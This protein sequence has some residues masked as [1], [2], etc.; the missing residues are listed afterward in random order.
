GLREALGK[1]KT[2]DWGPVLD[3]CQWVLSQPREIAGRE[4]RGIE[5]DPDW[6]WTR[7][8]IADLLSAGLENR[9]GS[10]P[11]GFREKVWAILEP[12]TEDPDPTP[13]D[14]QRYGEPNM[15]PATLA[16]NTTRGVAME[17]AIRYALWVQRHLEKGP[18]SKEG[19]QKGFENMPEVREV[20]N[21]HLNTAKDPSLAIRAVY[22]FW[23]PW[24]VVL[25]E[26]W[27]REHVGY[28]FPLD[29][30]QEAHFDAA[31]DTYVSFCLPSETSK[32]VFN[33]LREQYYHAVQRVG[34]RE[35]HASWPANPDEKLAEHLMLLYGYGAL[36]LEDSLLADFWKKASDALRGYAISFI[37]RIVR[38]C[39]EVPQEVLD[40]LKR[41]WET[42]LEVAKQS[43]SPAEFAKE[44]A[45]FGWWFTSDKF[46]VS[47]AL[48]NL[49]ESLRL[50]RKTEPTSTVLEH[51]GKTAQQYPLQSVRCLK[52]IAEGDQDGWELHLSMDHIQSILERAL[53]DPNSR[54]EA[55]ATINYLISRGFLKLKEL[56]KR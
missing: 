50:V 41:L 18:D 4:I 53:R 5:A 38:T 6:D 3:L 56:L 19:L 10:I 29:E 42:R 47:W 20:L 55:E 26:Q 49:L 16:I 48:E 23:F 21:T 39:R 31:W 2:F 12:L 25:D 24:L 32:S 30:N 34:T 9:P 52:M 28:I 13:E 40:R 43:Q 15:D 37:G 51:L 46:D 22:G 54:K 17:A 35:Y 14:E 44:L 36:S 27:A 45:A 33:L 1:E 7:K 11:I 8:A